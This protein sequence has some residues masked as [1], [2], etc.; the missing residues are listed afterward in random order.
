M[1]TYRTGVRTGHAAGRAMAMHLSEPTLD[2]ERARLAAYYGGMPAPVEGATTAIP[3]SDADPRLARLL[4]I[5]TARPPTEDELALLLSGARTDGAPVSGQRVYNFADRA[6]IAYLD[7]TWSADK[8]VSLAMA[9]A[10]TDAER[11][12]IV[13]AHR[14]AVAAAMRAIEG[15]IARAR[16]GKAGSGG[17][18]AGSMMWLEF[19]HYTSRPTVE[20]IKVDPVNGREYTEIVTAKTAG[21][22]QLHSHVLIPN[23]VMTSSGRV[24]GLFLQRLNGRI[25]EYGAIYQAY[26]AKH[27]RALGI[28]TELDPRTGAARVVA[29]PET[30]RTAFSKRTAGGLISAKAQAGRAG[31]DWDTLESAHRVALVKG[32]TQ[33]DKRAPKRDDLGDWESWRTEAAA[34]GW[35]PT[36]FVDPHHPITSREGNERLVYATDVAASLLDEA[37]TRRAVVDASTIRTMAA[38]SLVQAGVNDAADVANV[39]ERLVAGGVLQGGA[40]TTLLPVPGRDGEG[41]VLR[42]STA[43][44]LRDESEA[45]ALARAAAADT[46]GALS[47]VIIDNAVMRSGLDLT[48]PH[49]E[50]QRRAMDALAGGGR[51]SVITGAAGSG[52]TATLQPLVDAWTDHGRLVFGVALAWRQ[53]T[54]LTATGIPEERVSAL[55]PFLASADRGDLKL[56]PASV[57]IVDEI[58]LVGTRALLD[59]LRLQAR[60][61]FRLALLGDPLQA[62]SIDAGPTVDLL[63]Q[64]LGDDAIASITSTVRQSTPAERALTTAIRKGHIGEVIDA[65]RQNGS[66]LLIAGTPQQVAA[67]IADHWQTMRN[68]SPEQSISITAPT[69]DECRLI[70]A[71]IREKR[72][73]AG[74]IKGTEIEIDAVDNKSY[75]YKMK[76]AAGDRVRLF[77][78]TNAR[79][80]DGK[81]GIIGVNGSVLTVLSFSEKGIKLLNRNGR[82]GNVA[83]DTLRD[84]SGHIMLSYGDA[85]TIESAQGI[86]SDFHIAA[87]PKGTGSVD[88]ARAYVALSRHR[89]AVVTIVADAPVRR[90]IQ[91]SRPLG[92]FQP[93]TEGMVWDRITSDLGRRSPETTAMAALAVAE[94]ANVIANAT[95]R[96]EV[97]Y[98]E[99]MLSRIP[100]KLSKR[101]RYNNFNKLVHGI[102]ESIKR[103]LHRNFNEILSIKQAIEIKSDRKVPI[104][105]K[106]SAPS[107]LSEN[108]IFHPNESFKM[109]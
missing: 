52:K 25:H 103:S 48:G 1:L 92:D 107:E 77:R 84:E 80:E 11:G 100:K 57:V 31:L 33:G 49:G 21:D 7:C 56:S 68:A 26:L 19:I 96:M 16:K 41:A 88:A 63:R 12:M 38:R 65:K 24:G 50:Q 5:D 54:D 93:I 17:H 10:A 20:I 45:I 39:V 83:W 30:I 27:L 76:I 85:M 69:N 35:R 51:L 67:A 90:A 74:Q 91:S 44:H 97:H 55:V 13:C 75:H 81:R 94:Q 66:A 78:R 109:K 98:I 58:S 4:G 9:F 37:L 36:G 89:H 29:V 60:F 59:L 86:T 105:E 70:A 15:E 18:D 61:G 14:D 46:Q 6:S 104:L 99:K 53:A 23:V 79:C 73:D 106:R 82:V 32:G 62:A 2:P 8:S 40:R 3:R 87:F 43:L 102:S 72:R 34:L 108:V 42:Y 71:A 95:F 22:P 101:F 28:Q 47:S 64:A